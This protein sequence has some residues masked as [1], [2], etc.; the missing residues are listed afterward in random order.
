MAEDSTALSSPTLLGK[1][2]RVPADQA[3]WSTLAERCGCKI[4]GLCRKP[5]DSQSAV[6]EET[7]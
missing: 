2:A 4:Y 6:D 7:P 1:L 3:A 5:E